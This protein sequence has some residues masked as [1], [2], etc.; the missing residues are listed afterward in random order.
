MSL[1]GA[2]PLMVAHSTSRTVGLLWLNPSET[3]IDVE[4]A[5]T[6]FSG[7]ISNLVSGETKNKLTPWFS[8]T[9]VVDVFF[10]LG[11]KSSDVMQ[12]N[13]KLAGTTQLPPLYSIGYHQCRWNYWN[14]GLS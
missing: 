10:L 12:Q 1:Y 6:G 4:S 13:A 3:W 7:L 14:Q 9:G 5:N 8:E 2:Y 11:P